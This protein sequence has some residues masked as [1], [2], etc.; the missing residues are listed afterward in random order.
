MPFARQQNRTTSP[1][2]IGY[3]VFMDEA[4]PSG[5]KSD[6]DLRGDYSNI[7]DDYTVPQD[8]SAYDEVEHDRWRRLYARQAGLVEHYAAR[9]FLEGLAMLDAADAIPDFEKTNR[10]LADATG[11]HIVCVPGFIPDAQFFDHL[12][13]RRFPVTRWIREE[14]ELDYLVEPDLFHDFFGHVPMLLQPT[15][16]DFLVLYGK[17]GAKAMRMDALDMLARIYW[18]T[19]EFGLMEEDGALKAIGAGMLS[20]SGETVFSV[21]DPD[22]LRLPFDPERIMRTAY[23]IDDF[24]QVYFVLESLEQLI[25]GLMGLD[26]TPIYEKYRVDEG[27]EPSRLLP[28]ESAWTSEKEAT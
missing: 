18:Y 17:A 10:I 9:P 23:R 11:W 14:H 3:I 5:A 27:F 8:W 22:V 20:S 4:R 21:T 1:A 24:Q 2:S 6:S 28:G 7:A 13:N 19:V 25:D 12:A 26:F 16:A 15:F